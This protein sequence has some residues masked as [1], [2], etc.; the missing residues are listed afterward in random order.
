MSSRFKN[1]IAAHSTKGSGRLESAPI[2]ASLTLL[3]FAIAIL[4]LLC[5][6]FCK[7]SDSTSRQQ[8]LHH[9]VGNA[10]GIMPVYPIFFMQNSMS[11]KKTMPGFGRALLN[12]FVRDQRS[13]RP[14]PEPF[15]RASTSLTVTRLK[16]PEMVCLRQ[17][18]AT[19]NSSASAWVL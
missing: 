10:A 5:K 6:S 19:A 4:S 3:C 14:E 18:A 9:L 1:R 15:I 13:T 2:P 16:S 12:A 7:A 11:R 8:D 17:E